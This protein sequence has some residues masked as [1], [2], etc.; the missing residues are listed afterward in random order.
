M[1]TDRH[2]GGLKEVFMELIIGGAYQGKLDYARRMKRCEVFF[3]CAPDGADPDFSADVV[4]HIERF[5]LKCL[6]ENRSALDFFESRKGEWTRCILIADDIS[7]GVVPIDP[8]MR[9]WREETGR[10]LAHLAG[11]AA[12]VHRVFCGIGQVIQ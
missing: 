3:S 12:R 1:R 10:L 2:G 11:E 9:A 8:E 5:V 7:S 6:R 4:E